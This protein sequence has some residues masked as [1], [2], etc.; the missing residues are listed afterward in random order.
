MKIL[1]GIVIGFIAARVATALSRVLAD[2]N[3]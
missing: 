2:W 1:V 3:Y